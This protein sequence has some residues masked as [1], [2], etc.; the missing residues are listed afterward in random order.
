MLGRLRNSFVEV[1]LSVLEQNYLNLQTVLKTGGQCLMAPMV[2]ADAYGHGDV[3]V[4]RVCEKLGARFLG[5]AL[6]EEGIKL[7]LAG[8]QT[9]LLVFT[10]FD[11][12][13]AEALVKYRLTPVVNQRDQIDKLKRALHEHAGYPVHLKFNTGMNRLGFEP[14]EAS[15]LASEFESEGYL[16]LEG[17]CTHFAASEDFGEPQ[18]LTGEQISLFQKA[19]QEIKKKVQWPLLFHYMNSAAILTSLEPALDMARPGIALY[20]AYPKLNRKPA[21]VV[22]PVMSVKS[23]IGSVRSIKK[24]TRVSYSGTWRAP[25]N[26]VIAVCPVGYADG[27]PRALSNVGKVLVRGEFCPIVGIV[28]MD[29][30]LIDVTALA[31]THKGPDIGDEVVLLGKQKDRTIRAEEVADAAK[32]ISY[33][34]LTGM[35]NRL[36]RVFIH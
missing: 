32:T 36:P 12:M 3:Q 33:E 22:N 26:S 16:K 35:Q 25:K 8:I 14:E 31:E 23:F 9:P 30:I 20:G 7:R 13:G 34:I 17:V 19:S 18:G 5:V 21:A 24:G 29:Y 4:S 15:W 28:C 1:D 27:I 6:I 11:S 10:Q 2:K